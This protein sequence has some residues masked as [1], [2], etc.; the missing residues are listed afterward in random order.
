MKKN[1]IVYS[2]KAIDDLKNLA[3]YIIYTCKVPKTSSEYA[4]VSLILFIA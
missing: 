3:N 2:E 4:K 1:K